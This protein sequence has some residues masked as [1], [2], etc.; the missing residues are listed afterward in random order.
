REIDTRRF[1]GSGVA[2]GRWGLFVAGAHAA[3]AGRILHEAFPGA[4]AAPEPGCGGCGGGS[5]STEEEDAPPPGDW[6]EDGDWW[7][8]GAPGEDEQ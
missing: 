3:A 5:C 2:V 6:D 7:K 1:H 4:C 8:T